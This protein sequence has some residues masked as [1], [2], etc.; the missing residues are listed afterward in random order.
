[1]SACQAQEHGQL[2]VKGEYQSASLGIWFLGAH[3]AVSFAFEP[4]QHFQASIGFAN[5][6]TSRNPLERNE[7]KGNC[8]KCLAELNFADAKI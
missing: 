7:V 4:S 1:V 3:A 8:Q 5:V 6:W 2:R